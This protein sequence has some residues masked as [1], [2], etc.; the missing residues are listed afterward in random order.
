MERYKKLL[1][2]K[3]KVITL[4]KVAKMNGDLRAK[5]DLSLILDNIQFEIDMLDIYLG[6]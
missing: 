3:K 2:Y 4:I 6:V 1:A 5:H